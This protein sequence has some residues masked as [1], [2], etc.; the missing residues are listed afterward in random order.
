M[1]LLFLSGPAACGKLT[2]AR[3]V[4]AANGWK[5]FHNHLAIDLCLSLFAFGEPGFIALRDRV[6]MAAF[7]E[8]ARSGMDGMI[9]T[10][11]PEASVPA[12]F[13]DRVV[14]TVE[15]AG[16]EVIFVELTCPP[17][18]QAARVADPSRRAFGKLH[19]V[20]QLKALQASGKLDPSAPLPPPALRLDSGRLSPAEAAAAILRLL[21]KPVG[22]FT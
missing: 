20:A 12:D 11:A 14:A 21:D 16:G 9:F 17:E 22:E 4:V 10:F 18:V 3:E 19:D 5:L 6:W 2:V 7:E 1:R 8:A 15:A 13:I